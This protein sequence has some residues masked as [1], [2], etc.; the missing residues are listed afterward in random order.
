MQEDSARAG[1]G[2]RPSLSTSILI[3]LVLGVATGIF[4]GEYCAPLQIVGDGF[5]KLL[6]MTILPYIVVSLI[7]G[8]GSLNAKQAR[9][10]ALKGGQLLLLFWLIAFIFIFAVPLAFPT[11]QSASFF[12][13]AL[14]E[15]PKEIDFLELYIP[16]N[17]F[18]SL[19]N[20]IVPAVVLFCILLGVA[21]IGMQ[22]K[23]T[24]LQT[25]SSLSQALVRVT[26]LVVKLTPIGV[27]AIAAA[28]AGTMS[29]EEFGKLQVYLVSFNVAVLILTFWVL[30]MLLTT[31]TPFHYR[32]VIGVS[33]TA[34]I[35]AFATGNLF[36]V[37]AVLM[38]NCRAL[39]QKYN[40][41]EGETDSYIDVLVPVSF[42]FPNIGKLLMLVFVPFAGWYSGNMLSGADYPTFVFAGLLSFFGGVDVAL[43][44]MLDLMEIPTDLYQI[45]LVTGVVNGR[46][47][48][49][50][51]AMNLI[52]FTALA[53]AV[54]TNRYRV[55]RR[56][57][58]MFVSI[59]LV[60]T[61]AMVVGL[62]VYFKHAIQY[63]YAVA[64]SFEE[65]RLLDEPVRSRERM[66]SDLTPEKRRPAQSVL[67]RVRERGILRVGYRRDALPFAY[68]NRE[69]QLVGFD[70]EMAHDLARTLGV[71]LE[72]VRLDRDKYLEQL[73]DGYADI[74]MSG[75]DVTPQASEQVAFSTSYMDETVA[76]VVKD[77]MR[78]N[79]S[80]WRAIQ[81]TEGLRVGIV[82]DP[83]W[84]MAYVEEQAQQYLGE[85]EVTFLDSP[86]AFFRETAGELDALVHTAQGGA[87]WTVLYPEYT[88]VVPQPNL[89]SIPLAYPMARGDERLLDFVNAWLELKKSD[90]TFNEYYGHWIR[91]KGA[92]TRG[93]RW[94]VVRNVLGWV[95]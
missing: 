69:G 14:I 48:T 13:D 88:V 32:D 73:N 66:L 80:T 41:V 47:S 62:R 6:Q 11:W 44:F 17:P 19:A 53:T 40:L 34:L 85:A 2:W 21:L 82:K 26:S 22:E 83:Y 45:Y 30:P 84:N 95:E 79:F 56:R 87:A 60:I 1:R 12:S 71:D 3:G 7:L 63:E 50:L 20:T 76:F 92:E 29:V 86:R 72:F 9:A 70:A 24:L 43:P 57:L 58:L 16:H 28:A 65:M 64:R 59:T 8:I 46:S 68:R 94:S 75:I 54:L 61:A 77:H 27:F 67:D 81:N 10:M 4:F 51:A 35:T 33:R 31:A 39:F 89:I 23:L 74:I 25:L 93:P 52:V 55:N 36:V 90:R 38:D 49:L 5:V 91:G 15:S 42:N 78:D 37:L 18:Y